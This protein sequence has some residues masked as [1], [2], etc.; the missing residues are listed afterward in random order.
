MELLIHFPF[1][2]LMPFQGDG[3]SSDTQ[4]VAQFQTP[5]IDWLYLYPMA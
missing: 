3:C 2:K 4:G 1:S 5:F